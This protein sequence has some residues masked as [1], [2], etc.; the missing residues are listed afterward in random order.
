MSLALAVPLI[1][2][3]AVTIPG[4]GPGTAGAAPEIS[5]ALAGKT[6]FV[7]PGHQGADHTENLARQ[8]DNGR[9]GTKDCQTTGMTSMH[10]VPE[11]T[12]N[13]K[14]AQ[15]V[16]QS[17]QAMGATVVMSRQD[18]TGWGGCVDER[19]AAAN[20]SG[21]AVAVSIHADGAPA[22]D[23]GFHLI[24]PALPVPDAK[25]TQ[26][27]SGPGRAATQAVHDAYVAAGFTPANY[28]GAVDGIQTRDDIAGPALTEVPDVFVEMGNGAN[29]D[30]A[31]QLETPEGQLRHAIAITNGLIGFLTGTA[32]PAAAPEPGLA[33]AVVPAPAPQPESA[34]GIAPA[35]EPAPT[36]GGPAAIALPVPGAPGVA[37]P[38][39]DPGAAPS[40]DA[41][42]APY[43]APGAAA[44]AGLAGNA[45]YPGRQVEPAQPAGALPEPAGVTAA[46]GQYS[47]G[48][49]QGA[50][51]LVQSLAQTILGQ[52]ANGAGATSGD[53]TA[54]VLG[55]LAQSLLGGSTGTPNS[56]TPGAAGPN[57]YTTAPQTGTPNG[58]ANGPQ[59]TPST[60][61]AVADL[62]A[63]A[64][65]LLAPL[66]QSLLG[67]GTGAPAATG[68]TSVTNALINL[69]YTL[70]STLL[71]PGK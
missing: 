10:G 56:S 58:Y 41:G 29:A 69:A 39:G 35:P 64:L 43:T 40:T 8:V 63:L 57:S 49:G 18:D 44:Q 23:H 47:T 33:P 54:S 27:Q 59:S 15:L 24:V 70:V 34:P 14:V 62:T 6:V 42:A 7:D 53:S 30:D 22:E 13:W 16:Q 31:A 45:G 1:A 46:P 65:R 4:A 17:L 20:R 3:T 71:G 60:T 32:V 55:T 9:G 26:V 21:A 61:G 67:G 50:N 5:T 38:Y 48:T 36:I 2:A 66:G 11:H 68:N 52:N 28:A 25:A 37:A 12:I 19:A 51:N